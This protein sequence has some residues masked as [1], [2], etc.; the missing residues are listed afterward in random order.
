MI[1][2]I[3]VDIV[4]IQRLKRA[5]ERWGDRFLERVFTEGEITYCLGKGDPYASLAVRFAAKE[6]L[7]K[8]V[9]AGEGRLAFRDIEIVSRRDGNPSIRPAGRLKGV[10][11]GKGITDVHLSLSH[12]RHYGVAFVVAEKTKIK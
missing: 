8:A 9:G 1:K 11:E 10:L 2:G 5:V 7:L 12:E 4:D 3:G 6:A